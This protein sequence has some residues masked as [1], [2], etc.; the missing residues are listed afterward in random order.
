MSTA[1]VAE[2]V[3]ERPLPTPTRESQAY[4]DGMRAGRCMLQHCAGDGKARHEPRPG[5][6][7]RW[8]ECWRRGAA[9]AACFRSALQ[10]AWA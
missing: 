1:P 5:S 6:G 3:P 2:P 7:G 8:R 9:A 10:A 4:W